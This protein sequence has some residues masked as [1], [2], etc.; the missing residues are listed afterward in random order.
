MSSNQTC[1]INAIPSF[2]S[3]P[4]PQNVAVGALSRRN[5]TLIAMQKCCSPNPV[6][7]VGDCVLWCEI[8]DRFTGAEW[9]DCTDP[10]IMDPH[11]VEYRNEGPKAITL[12]PLV[13][14]IA[15]FALLIASIQAS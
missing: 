14:G 1:D 4:I 5:D 13:L 15:T 6:N 10:Y 8:P 12:H 7:S 3:L 9:V 2:E 11:G